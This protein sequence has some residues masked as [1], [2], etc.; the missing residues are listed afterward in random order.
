MIDWMGLDS[1][2]TEQLWDPSLLVDI[3]QVMKDHEPFSRTDPHSA[4]FDDLQTLHS[5]IT[6]LNV[7]RDG[8][9]RTAFRKNNPMTKLGLTTPETENAFVTELGTEVLSNNLNIRDVFAIA[10]S[11]HTEEDGKNSFATMCEAALLLPDHDFTVEDVEFGVSKLENLTLGSLTKAITDVR[12]KRLKISDATR[13]RRIR[14][15]VMKMLVRSGALAETE[16]GWRLHDKNQAQ[17]IAERPVYETADL[18]VSRPVRQKVREPKKSF[19]VIKTENRQRASFDLS[20]SGKADPVKTAIALERSSQLHEN[21]VATLGKELIEL[22]LDT[23]EDP[24][25]FDIAILKKQSAI[26]EVKTVTPKNAIAQIRKAVVQLEEYRWRHF[27]HFEKPPSLF[28]VLSQNP[29][30]YLDADYFNFIEQDRQM[31]IIW[32]EQEFVDRHGTA[33]Q[34]LLTHQQ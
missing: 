5:N 31:K 21:I 20:K 18:D 11:T 32:Q 23:F 13:R 10:L 1:G 19:S 28:I 22:G 14:S 7:N 27:K 17:S 33:L 29:A 12:D 30:Q 2:G 16:L 25:S 15:S 6:W 34:E 8:S 24:D 4:I 3:L 9:Q 26:F